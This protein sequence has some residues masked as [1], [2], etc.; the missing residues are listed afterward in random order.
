M[1]PLNVSGRR[2]SVSTPGSPSCVSLMP[3]ITSLQSRDCD[4]FKKG[5][6]G[7]AEEIE[8]AVQNISMAANNQH[9]PLLSEAGEPQPKE[10][11]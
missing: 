3:P 10:V 4:G 1:T 7:H 8:L 9:T 2:A 5:S 11:L 6:S